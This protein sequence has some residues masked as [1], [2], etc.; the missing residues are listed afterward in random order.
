MVDPIEL[1]DALE[2]LHAFLEGADL[3]GAV[4]YLRTLHPADSAELIA[5][6]E[7][8]QQ[9]AVIDRL[10]APELAEVFEQLDEEDM[11]DVAQHLD[12]EMLADVLDEMEPDMAADLLGELEPEQAAEVLEQMEEPADVAAL[13]TYAPD[14]AGGIMTAAPPSLRRFWTVAESICFLRT[15][16]AEEEDFFTLYVLDRHARLI[17]LVDLKALILAEPEQTIE[18]IMDRNVISVRATADQ[19]E[20]AQLLQRYDLVSLPVVDDEERLIGIVMID[21]VVD[22]IEEE[23]TEDIYR[24]AQMSPDS[25][26]YSPI[27]ESVRNRLPWLVVNLATAFLASSV[28]TLFEGT[29][30]QAAVLAAF[31]PIVA[32][33]GGNAGTQTMTIIVRSLALKEIAP[34]DTFWALWHEARVG[35]IN[36]VSVGI[37]VALIAGVWQGNP[38]LGLVIGL[39]MLGN[40]IIAALA[41]VFVPMMLKLVRVDPALASSIFVTTFTDVFGFLLFLG[42]ATYFLQYLD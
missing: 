10:Q 11:A 17:G 34:R 38:Y 18:E 40:L 5:E 28:V 21:D 39:A 31:M 26:I 14:T 6:L 42:L 33:Q 27:P 29:I 41:G 35:I 4:A 22:V 23:A 25:E 24:L 36:G 13:M 16:Y 1:N 3:E 19:E 20:V 32:G 7:P 12:V 8:E 37:L 30:A 9:A 15:H 2:R